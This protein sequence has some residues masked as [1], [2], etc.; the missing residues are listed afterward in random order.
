LIVEDE[1]VAQLIQLSLERRF[2]LPKKPDGLS[3][4]AGFQEQQTGLDPRLDGAW[5]DGRSR[6][7]DRNLVQKT[8][9]SDADG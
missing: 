7:Y 4:V 5:F 9:Y 8:L 3:V 1:P 2:F 6:G